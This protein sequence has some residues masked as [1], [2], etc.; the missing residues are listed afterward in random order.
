MLPLAHIPKELVSTHAPVRG[1]TGLF[2]F[3]T[4]RLLDFSFN[5]RP[6]AGANV[7]ANLVFALMRVSIHAPD[8]EGG[9]RP[10]D[11]AIVHD[12]AL[13]CG[14]PSID[15]PHSKAGALQELRR[16]LCAIGLTARFTA[17]QRPEPTS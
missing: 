16:V 3:S 2:N 13:E 17:W 4:F 7:G 11:D 6:R 14:S 8:V 5:P 15:G 1:R 9:A 10:S 12:V